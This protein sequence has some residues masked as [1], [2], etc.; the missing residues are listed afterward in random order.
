MLI[1]ER[2]NRASCRSSMNLVLHHS[3]APR[4][5][6]IFLKYWFG[7]GALSGKFSFRYTIAIF[8]RS[9]MQ[10]LALTITFFL[11]HGLLRRA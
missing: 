7:E 3:P 5:R 6:G 11:R 4:N 2:H 8:L 1:T 10:M 9:N